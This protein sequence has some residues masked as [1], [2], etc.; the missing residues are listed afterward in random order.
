[1]VEAVQDLFKDLPD[2]EVLV[3]LKTIQDCCKDDLAQRVLATNNGAYSVLIKLVLAAADTAVQL[4]LVR[5]LTS[6]MNTNP[7]MLE[8]QGI[9]A[10]NKILR[11]GLSRNY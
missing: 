11:L 6:V 8:A 7:D 3:R 2:E 5:T 4:E 1:M 10:I 9:D